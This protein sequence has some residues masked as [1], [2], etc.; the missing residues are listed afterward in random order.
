DWSSMDVVARSRMLPGSPL[1]DNGFLRLADDGAPDQGPATTGPSKVDWMAQGLMAQKALQ[2]QGANYLKSNADLKVK[3][4]ANAVDHP[5]G[6]VQDAGDT[7]KTVSQKLDSVK[8]LLP[9]KAD[10]GSDL[11][12][13]EVD[14]Q[15]QEDAKDTGKV[16]RGPP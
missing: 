15:T 10:K 8:S 12:M 13:A 5:A 4:V 11:S 2:S 9:K 6:L 14:K 7:A 16:A 3:A 1:V